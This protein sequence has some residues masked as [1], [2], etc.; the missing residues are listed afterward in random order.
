MNT[1]WTKGL[2]AGSQERKDV[3]EAFAASALLRKRMVVMLDEMLEAEANAKH[4]DDAYDNPSW[5]Y[6]QADSIGYIR[7][8]KKLRSVLT[9][10]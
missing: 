3:E 4:S 2:K 7:A 6:K 8:V 5:A 10:R 1:L 9:E